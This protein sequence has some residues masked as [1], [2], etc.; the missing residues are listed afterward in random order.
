MHI[1]VFLGE[2]LNIH[3][4]NDVTDEFICL[5]CLHQIKQIL[6]LILRITLV[7]CINVFKQFFFVK[8]NFKFY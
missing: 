6:F 7:C 3:N 1:Y 2:C 5:K 4:L 8:D